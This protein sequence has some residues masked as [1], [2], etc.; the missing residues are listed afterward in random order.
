M[1]RDGQQIGEGIHAVEPARIDEAHEQVAGLGAKE[2][3]LAEAVLAMEDRHFQGLLAAVI[4]QRRA[5]LT[6]EQGQR[7][8]MFEH[9]AYGLSEAGVGLDVL[10]V[11]SFPHP[12]LEPGHHRLAVGLAVDEPRLVR[13]AQC[14]GLGLKT[15]NFSQGFEHVPTVRRETGRHGQVRGALPQHIGGPGGAYAN[16]FSRRCSHSPTSRLIARGGR[17]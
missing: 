15:V 12:R 17:G 4:I 3:L 14:F 13:E 16:Q 2:R 11:E 9:I 1:R 6:E 5:G 10:A 7:L 8:P